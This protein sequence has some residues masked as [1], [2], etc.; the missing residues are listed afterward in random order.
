MAPGDSYVGPTG[1]NDASDLCKCNTVV[2]SLMSACDACQFD[3]AVWFSYVFVSRCLCPYL[4]G[5]DH[6]YRWK[7]WS[8]NCTDVE[9]PSTFV[10][11][12]DLCFPHSP[13]DSLQV[14]KYDPEW[15]ERA[16][17]GF[18]RCDRKSA[19]ETTRFDIVMIGIVQKKGTWDPVLSYQV[20][21]E[22][23]PLKIAI[24]DSHKM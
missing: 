5:C 2:Y 20:G 18:S 22:A 15:D 13:D 21:G 12:P 19:S 11:S 1:S 23:T 7:T 3:D 14:L 6:R 17:M 9:P 8:V 4:T 16:S 10:S 24:I